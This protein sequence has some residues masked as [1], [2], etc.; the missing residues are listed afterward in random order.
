MILSELNNEGQPI[1]ER[2]WVEVFGTL[3]GS[4]LTMWD[5]EEMEKG[6]LQTHFVNLSDGSM[7]TVETL[8]N[9]LTNV[10]VLSTTMRNRFLLQFATKKA[11]N[12]WTAAIRLSFFE[13]IGLQEAYTGALLSY[14]GSK[15]NGIRY[16][17][18]E[19]KYR[20]ESWCN[21]RF[22]VGMPWRRVW[23]V[24]TPNSAIKEKKLRKSLAPL[25]K[26]ELYNDPKDLK[27]KK[28]RPLAVIHQAYAVF[29]VFPEKSVLV[30]ISTLIKMECLV[31]FESDPQLRESSLFLMP[32]PIPAVPGC[33]TLIRFIIPLFDVFA[34]YGRPK[35]LNADKNDV[36]SL[37]FGMP[38]LPH[39]YYLDVVDVYMLASLGE[40][41]S[42]S[43]NDWHNRVK[44]LIAQ[45]MATGYKGT[46]NIGR[47]V[48]EGK[49]AS[50]L[51]S[52]TFGARARHRDFSD[53]DLKLSDSSSS[54]FAQRPAPSAPKRIAEESS[55]SPEPPLLSGLNITNKARNSEPDAENVFAD[56]LSHHRVNSE[57]QERK[58]ALLTPNLAEMTGQF[59]GPLQQSSP[60]DNSEPLGKESHKSYQEYSEY[61]R[62]YLD[63]RSV[64][65]NLNTEVQDSDRDG[66]VHMVESDT[67]MNESDCSS[68]R[69]P[70][71]GAKL[72]NTPKRR[73]EF[74]ESR[75]T[76]ADSAQDGRSS[77]PST[78]ASGPRLD[79]YPRQRQQRRPSGPRPEPESGDSVAN[80]DVWEFNDSLH[81]SASRPFDESTDA[82][83]AFVGN[84]AVAE[85]PALG[86][87]PVT[88]VQSG[89][90]SAASLNSHSHSENTNAEIDDHSMPHAAPTNR[91]YAGQ[92]SMRQNPSLRQP[93]AYPAGHPL[94][95]PLGQPTGHQ[96]S[97]QM[98][99]QMANQMAN[100][101]GNQ[102]GNQMG[103]PM[104]VPTMPGNQMNQGSPMSGSPMNGHPMMN[105]NPMM[106]AN[107]MMNSNAMPPRGPPA[108]GPPRVLMY[109]STGQ[110]IYQ[111]SQPQYTGPQIVPQGHPNVNPGMGQNY[112]NMNSP[113]QA[114]MQA[115]RKPMLVSNQ[116]PPQSATGNPYMPQANQNPYMQSK[117]VGPAFAGGAQN[118]PTQKLNKPEDLRS[119]RAKL[120]GGQFGI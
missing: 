9:D 31:Q 72:V 44:E 60:E 46:G 19:S 83:S 33:E 11:F 55:A 119:A 4:I 81:S 90:N 59:G 5:A 42:W 16:M 82:S 68:V 22:G 21:I 87:I 7:R 84:N 77:P 28:A 70:V 50:L 62:Q 111:Q 85:S 78:S 37:L 99:N 91:Q 92:P 75:F 96:V 73:P 36:N 76:E 97:N 69:V 101:M 71:A 106:N 39:A 13:N 48:G 114:S 45:K 58:P 57:G 61:M 66:P 49:R 25:G 94:G 14:K 107:P 51:A 64:M 74:S 43:Q 95:N 120:M 40:S 34:L 98:P 104:T 100:P 113:P 93:A 86:P 108:A 110:P 27:K 103:T 35:R 112:G 10:I 89:N 56:P 115:F 15:L 20:T 23:V 6:N 47:T 80:D 52:P 116:M 117:P 26:V 24:V 17:L 53:G 3:Q 12:E 88:F 54:L 105:G 65:P 8:S 18:A 102:M 118:I 29:A 38:S 79:A 109:T 1:A 63:R 2:K 41:Q 30:N 32:E 67:D